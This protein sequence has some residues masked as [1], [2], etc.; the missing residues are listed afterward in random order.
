MVTGQLS[1]T[2]LVRNQIFIV[3][4]R[5]Q[6]ETLFPKCHGRAYRTIGFRVSAKVT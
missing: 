1:Q 4:A 2:A 6:G 5:T 3:E